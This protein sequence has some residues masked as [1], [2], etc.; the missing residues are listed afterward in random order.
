[1]SDRKLRRK[2]GAVYFATFTCYAWLPLIHCV[3]AYDAVYNWNGRIAQGTAGHA[4]TRH[5]CA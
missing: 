1:M 2:D 5:R 3:N 4:L